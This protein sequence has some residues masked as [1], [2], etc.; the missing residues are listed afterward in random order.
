METLASSAIEWG[1]AARALLGQSSSGDRHIVKPFPRG[2]LLAAV[3]GLGHGD[4]AASAARIALATLAARAEEPVVTVVQ[5]CHEGLRATRGVVMSI[6]SFNVA[7]GLMTWLGVGNVQG[8][9]L[10]CAAT[11]VFP[12]ESLLLRS[13]VVG[14]ELPTLQAAM[15]SVSVGD[16]LVLST[17]GIKSDFARQLVRNHLPQKAAEHILARY[18]KPTDDALVLVARYVGGST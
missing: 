9:L 1:V 18:S 17:D 14:V 2:V 12:E 3:D 6:A 10:R 5:R 7:Q 8:V 11:P 13:G 16:T 15:L 4:E